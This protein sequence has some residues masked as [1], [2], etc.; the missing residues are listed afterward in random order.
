MNS[1][2]QNDEIKLLI[3]LFCLIVVS[4][5]SIAVHGTASYRRGG[6]VSF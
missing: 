6:S 4:L 1:Q 3:F 2:C 5:L